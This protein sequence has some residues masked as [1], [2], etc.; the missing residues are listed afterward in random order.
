MAWPVMPFAPVTNAT[1]GEYMSGKY[2][3]VNNGNE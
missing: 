2:W 1:F 3:A